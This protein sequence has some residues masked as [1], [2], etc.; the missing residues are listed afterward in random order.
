MRLMGAGSLGYHERTVLGRGDDPVGNALDYYA[1]RGETPMVWGGSGAALLGL[2]GEVDLDEWRAVFATG[3]A[4]HPGTHARLV[5]CM[6]PGM[7]LVISSHKSVAELGVVGRPEDMHAILDAERDATM[8]YLDEVV[9]EMG[10]RRGRAQVRT[11]TGGLTWAV[12]RHAT[13]RNGDPQPHDHI[14]LANVQKMGDERGGWKAVDTGLVRDHL[15]AATAIGRMAA[16]A[17]A[18]ELGYG[19][20]PDPGRSGRLGAWAIAG[21]PKEAWQVHASRQAEIDAAVGA[22]ASPEARSVAARATRAAKV[23]EGAEDL[24]PRWRDE[25]ARAGYPPQELSV[26]VERAGLAYEPPVLSLDEVVEELLRPGG[27]LASEKTFTRRDAIVA[28]APHLDGLPVPVLDEAL[29]KVL[30][31]E[32]SVA[33][34]LVRGAREPVYAAA[35]V[36]EDERRIAELAEVLAGRPG[37]AVS[38][39]AAAAAVAE[40][41]LARGF[42][43]TTRQAEVAVGILT[44]GH[45]ADFVLG[46]AGSGKSS[47]LGA[48]R[49]GFEAAGYRVIGTATSGQAAKALAEG[50]GISSRTVASLTWRLEHGQEALGPRHVLVLDE[51]AMSSDADVAKLLGAVEASGAKLVAV[52]DFRQLGPV[53]PG[54]A[55]EA[56]A[57]RHP[58]HVW[59]L[60]DNLRQR[61]PSE[62][63]ALEHLRH[64]NVAHAIGWYAREGRLHPAANR[65]M[66]ISEMARA[67]AADVAE[68]KDALLLAYHRDTVEALNRVAREA[69]E[70]LGRLSGPEVEAPGGRRYRAGDKVVALA[71]GPRGAWATSERAVVTSVDPANRSLV[72]LTPGGRLFHMGPEDIGEGKLAHGYAMTAHRSQGATVGVTHAL[73]DGG[74][75]ELAYVALSRARGESHVYAVGSDIADAALRLAWDWGQERRHAWVTEREPAKSLGQLF[76][77]RARLEASVPPDR[78]AELHGAREKLA[79]IE[80]D[81]RDLYDGAGRWARHPAGEATR[82]VRRTAEEHERLCERAEEPGLGLWARHKARRELRE[83]GAR[84]DQ[85]QEAWRHWAEPHARSLETE[86]S[87]LE[88][89]VARFSEAQ[90]RHD[91]FLAQRP[92]VLARIRELD[93]EIKER[94]DLARQH[95][96]QPVLE[97]ERERQLHRALGLGHGAEFDRG[98][99]IGIDL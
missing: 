23:H 61:D 46:V 90:Q 35:C 10:G 27:R 7:E 81:A 68:G 85:A 36:L 86:R 38:P 48:V 12:S 74:G 28:V 6:R 30:S 93:R 37:A 70:G 71:P 65:E 19:I 52:G 91:N 87:N 84:F 8:G 32:A 13:T 98:V 4:H 89:R 64:G 76:E 66:A 54:G 5:A 77:E 21:I 25:L 88:A 80:A 59:A 3:G 97:R 56:L 55:L 94:E 16:A 69:W 45:S 72:A 11:P 78:S 50:A 62:R 33:L 29:D 73:A 43:L 41:G 96:W 58:G 15:H 53:G 44:S 39:E 67:W 79:L 9:R 99:D 51:G 14:L 47:T 42:S 95:A 1:S 17:K 60:G 63:K 18:V 75:R 22:D 26:A 34:P 2:S 31:H 57:S 83:A 82:A 49:L 92:G 20:E 24:V 40:A